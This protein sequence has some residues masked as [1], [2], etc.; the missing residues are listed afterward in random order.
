MK[1][2]IAFMAIISLTLLSC[3]KNGESKISDVDTT[4]VEVKDTVQV[5]TDT[6][7]VVDTL[8]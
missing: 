2:T 5:V 4:N 3:V 8:K 6:I 1:K 7:V